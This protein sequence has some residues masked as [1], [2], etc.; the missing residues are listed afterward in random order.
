MGAGGGVPRGPLEGQ[1]YFW[2]ART[3]QCPRP[4]HERKSSA[5]SCSRQRIH[6]CPFPP[7]SQPLRGEKGHQFIGALFHR[8]RNPYEDSMHTRSHHVWSTPTPIHPRW[9]A[10]LVHFWASIGAALGQTRQPQPS[11]PE[12]PQPTTRSRC[13]TQTPVPP[14]GP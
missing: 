10:D 5:S 13:F 4:W 3:W 7:P 6:R 11:N 8:R 12:Q 1:L 9:G 14:R 2:C